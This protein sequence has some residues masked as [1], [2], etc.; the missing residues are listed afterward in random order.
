MSEV[1]RL[2]AAYEADTSNFE[3]GNRRVQQGISDTES[4][5]NR[6]G[7][8]AQS[9]WSNLASNALANLASNLLTRV[10]SSLKQ[11][12]TGSIESAASFDALERGLTAITGSAQSAQEQ[13][14]RLR[15]IAK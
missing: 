10:A 1:S 2:T 13:L 11:L 15:E 6:A 9:F 5:L 3:R 4:H 12:V 7:R 8:S 14:G